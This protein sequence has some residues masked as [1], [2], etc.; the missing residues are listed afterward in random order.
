MN[1]LRWSYQLDVDEI[2]CII[3]N[4]PSAVKCVDSTYFNH[5]NVSYMKKN[6]KAIE[7]QD[8]YRS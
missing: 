6:V 7:N 5:F 3:N 1:I 4:I 2:L 8:M